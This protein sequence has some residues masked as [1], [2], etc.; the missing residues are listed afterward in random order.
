MRRASDTLNGLLFISLE[1]DGD[2]SKLIIVN[3]GDWLGIKLHHDTDFETDAAGP[4]VRVT[5]PLAAVFTLVTH[6]LRY[7]P[8]HKLTFSYRCQCCCPQKWIFPECSGMYKNNVM[9]VSQKHLPRTRVERV[10]FSLQVRCANHCAN[11]ACVPIVIIWLC[12]Y[13]LPSERNPN[14]NTLCFSGS[15]FWNLTCIVITTVILYPSN[16]CV[17]R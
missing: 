17:C 16:N 13:L 6:S 3:E 4:R 1:A 15:S 12:C 2:F 8:T 9:S 14:L 11:A 7:P 5:E 10:T